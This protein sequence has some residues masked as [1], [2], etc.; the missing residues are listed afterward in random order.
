MTSNSLQAAIQADDTDFELLRDQCR[1]TCVR[2]LAA[3]DGAVALD[4]LAEVVAGREGGPA[5]TETARTELHH[6][7][8]PKLARAGIVDYD[9]AR[10]VVEP[11]QVATLASLLQELDGA[12]Q[13]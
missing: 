6:V 9:T 4:E 2:A 1:R 7:H 13:P 12:E 3:R 8:L 5:S 11:I 10:H